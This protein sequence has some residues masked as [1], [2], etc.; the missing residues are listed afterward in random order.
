M[1]EEHANCTFSLPVTRKHRFFRNVD[2][3]IQRY[4]VLG[5]RRILPAVKLINY[6]T[7]KQPPKRPNYSALG[8]LTKILTTFRSVC[9][10]IRSTFLPC[11]KC[12]AQGK[13]PATKCERL[14]HPKIDTK[15]AQT[16]FSR[17]D[18]KLLDRTSN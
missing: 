16:A 8:Q 3:L 13:P 4:R 9:Y 6:T 11:L 7:K 1:P 2:K 12:K 10:D 18:M 15:P 5:L 14:H 17:L